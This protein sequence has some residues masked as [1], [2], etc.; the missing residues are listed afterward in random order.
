MLEFELEFNKHFSVKIGD[1][2]IHAMHEREHAGHVGMVT[3]RRFQETDGGI[4]RWVVVRWMTPE[5]RVSG[6]CVSHYAHEIVPAPKV[7]G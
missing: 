1:R 6:E 7:E 2:V 3:E 4:E 5:G